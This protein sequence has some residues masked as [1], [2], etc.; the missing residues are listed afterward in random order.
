MFANICSE[1]NSFTC[2]RYC[3]L[4]WI[5]KVALVDFN[6][7]ID[8][9]MGYVRPKW[10]CENSNFITEEKSIISWLNYSYFFLRNNLIKSKEK[11]KLVCSYKK[12][13]NCSFLKFFEIV[14]HVFI[15]TMSFCYRKCN[16]S[17]FSIKIHCWSFLYKINGW[18][19]ENILLVI[20]L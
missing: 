13:A 3:L 1:V 5:E 8:T 12:W 18:L 16:V 11:W 9:S 17:E 7:H 15:F 14:C 19:L 20:S 2:G 4:Q 10:N 6:R